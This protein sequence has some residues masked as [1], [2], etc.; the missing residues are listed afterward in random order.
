MSFIRRAPFALF[1]FLTLLLGCSPRQADVIVLEVGQSKVNMGEYED[2]YA[3][4]AGGWET[5]RNSSIEDRA[6]F[7]DLLAAYKLKLQDAFSRG[8]QNDP[9]IGREMKEYRTSLAGT[10][11]IDREV[12]DPGVRLMY[13]RRKEEIRAQHILISVSLAASAMD[14]VDAYF[15]AMDIIHRAKA[16]ENFDSLVVRYSQD[17][18]AKETLGDLYYFTGGQMVSEFE[19]AAY[20]LKKGEVSST[21]VRT[22]FG[23][24]IIKAA[25]RQPAAGSIKVR[26]IMARFQAATADSSDSASALKRIRGIQDSLTRGWDFAKLAIKLSED[27]GSAQSG[28]DLGWFER[29]RWV[30]PFDEAA[31]NLK[32]GETSPIV[33]TTFGYHII[34]CDSIKPLPDFELVKEDFKKRYSQYR[35]NDDYLRYI[36]GLKE[37]FHYSFNEETFDSLSAHLDSTKTVEDSSWNASLPIPVKQMALMSVAGRSYSLDTVL[38][39]MAKSQEFRTTTLRKWDLRSK[40]DRVAENFLIEANSAN[41]E[42][43]HPEFA[44]L[45]KEY[46]DGV[47]LFKAEQAEVW[48]KIVVTDSGVRSYYNSNREKFMFPKR[49][50]IGEIHV[51]ADT[52]A[53]LVYDSLIHG[54]DFSEFASRYN[55]DTELKGKHGMRGL[56]SVETDQFTKMADTMTIGQ[57]TAPFE[58]EYGGYSIIK[59]I[60]KE[61]PRLKTFEEAG[62]EVSNA[63]QEY[64][65]KRLEQEWVDRLAQKFAVTKYKERLP[66]AFSTPRQSR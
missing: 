12:T 35:Y 38:A 17:A 60:S 24:H 55:D 37:K 22:K 62:A 39:I 11:L 18:N 29:R 33:H 63:F 1:V 45:M 46:E 6:H 66:K 40:T 9:E 31:F 59:A 26:H 27:A 28:G 13:E 7:L 32:P 5:A 23:Y 49:I 44:A 10:F 64:E 53:Y 56:L 50:S 25:D 54:G 20:A 34:H 8:L 47:V 16:G 2:F 57:I 58:S 19:N 51:E 30:Q 42:T 4:N 41:L 3:R 43:T 52:M 48:N 21:P 15:K 36:K 14:T 61:E 65:S